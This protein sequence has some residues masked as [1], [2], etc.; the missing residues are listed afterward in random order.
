MKFSFVIPTYNSEEYLVRCLKSI[1]TQNYSMDKV[2][3]II[4][5]GGSTDG[6]L[7]F[8]RLYGAK[9]LYNPRRLAEYALPIGARAATGDLLVILAADNELVGSWLNP[10]SDMFKIFPD[11]SCL[12]GKLKASKDDPS[13]VRYYELILS[14]PLAWFM[15]Q[16]LKNYLK[17]G[18]VFMVHSDKP[19][20]WGANGLV[21]RLSDVKDL[22]NVNEYV[23][24]CEFFQKM[25]NYGNNKVAYLENLLIYHH[26]VKS[27]WHWV[28]KWKRNFTEIFLKTR[29]VRKIDWL[30]NGNFK[31]KLCLWLVYSLCPLISGVHAIYL[32]IRDRNIHWLYHPLMC[33]LQTSTYIFWTLVLP[34][35]RRNLIE[36]IK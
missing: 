7:F 33:F 34:E 16:N 29:K 5:D 23:G 12:W 31:L 19:L 27:V 28:K 35:G 22:F 18:S 9:I 32:M 24:D 30:Y 8:A 14:E 25:V 2:E 15:N 26:T 13:I 6:T 10:V 3:I 11:L 17:Q 4:V 21:Y 1:V 20:C 36:H